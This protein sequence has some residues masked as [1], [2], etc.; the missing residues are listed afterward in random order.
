[1]VSPVALFQHLF[2][3]ICV[4]RHPCFLVYIKSVD[5]CFLLQ[6]MFGLSPAIFVQER[7]SH[8]SNATILCP[9]YL[10]ADFHLEN[11]KTRKRAIFHATFKQASS[12]LNQ[13][14]NIILWFCPFPLF[15][16]LVLP[17][18]FA[19]NFCPCFLP[20]CIC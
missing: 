8:T 7:H 2:V 6:Y 19:L 5:I 11:L 15:C 10:T 4:P 20:L 9:G 16:P 1:M 3:C 17:S 12:Y 18:I 14:E 13:W